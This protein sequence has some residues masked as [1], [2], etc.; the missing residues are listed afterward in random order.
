MYT[1]GIF[2]HTSVKTMADDVKTTEH[3]NMF[4]WITPVRQSDIFG[5]TC[6][7]IFLGYLC[8]ITDCR[9]KIQSQLLETVPLHICGRRRWIV[10]TASDVSPAE[11]KLSGQPPEKLFPAQGLG[12]M[13][14]FWPEK[15]EK[16]YHWSI[17]VITI[18]IREPL[19]TSS[20]IY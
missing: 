1:V 20:V 13:A 14:H 3:E 2:R 19:T 18:T 5:Q 16:S 7:H 11:V 8:H 17:K 4:P 12:A 9:I 15:S 6:L 10:V